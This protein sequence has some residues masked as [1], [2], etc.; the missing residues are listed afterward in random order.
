MAY[1]MGAALLVL[2]GLEGAA[3]LVPASWLSLRT[4][5]GQT[6]EGG[7]LLIPS[8]TRIFRF[9]EGTVNASGAPA[10]IDAD[11]LRLPLNEGPTDAPLIITLGD[12]SVFG[13]AMQDGQT[14]HDRLQANL[15]AAGVRTRVTTAAQPGYSTVQ[16][17]AVM[18]EA[19]WARKPSLVVVATMWSDSH[20]DRYRDAEMVTRPGPADASALYG[21]LRWGTDTVLGRA[22]AQQV[23]WPTP[24]DAGVRRV[25]L[26]DY[27]D[28]LDTLLDQ[29]DAHGASVLVLGLT[30]AGWVQAADTSQGS[31][32]LYLDM[33]RQ[34]AHAR[35]V[36]YVEGTTALKAYTGSDALFLDDLHPT[37]TGNDLLAA[38]VAKELVADGW[39]GAP[40]FPTEARSG[41]A[42]PEDPWD[43]KTA[44]PPVSLLQPLGGNPAEQ[45][46]PTQ[47]GL[48]MPGPPAGTLVSLPPLMQPGP[49]NGPPTG[50][51]QPPGM[52]GPPNGMQPGMS[53]PPGMPQPGPPQ[54]GMPHP[55]PPQPGMPGQP[56][57]R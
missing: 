24:S 11:G 17:L 6:P 3:R 19:G 50:S 20:L 52:P 21:L 12:S 46:A 14:L 36:P 8:P 4:A 41:V 42:V 22:T 31:S 33:L 44:A 39:P 37:A 23:G 5:G 15:Q 28:N 29:A 40:L 56:P 1:G 53:G 34:V 30:H 38:A 26:K 51:E 25:P 13:H 9:P 10:R 16:A 47:P 57:P 49:Q 54:P 7:S 45:T 55:G 2:A 32:A 43:G 18:D 48:P 27:R 35:S